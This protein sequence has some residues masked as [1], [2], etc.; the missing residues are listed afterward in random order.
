MYREYLWYVLKHKWYVFLACCKEGMPVRGLLH[1]MSKLRPSEFLPYAKFHANKRRDA[2]GHYRST[3]TGDEKFDYAWFL[4]QKR[5]PH[6]WQHW[7]QVSEE[8]SI[9]CMPIPEVYL[10]EMLCDWDGA[11]K[12]QGFFNEDNVRNHYL[13]NRTKRFMH[14]DATAYIEKRLEV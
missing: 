10:R 14:P 12:A 13:N 8:G 7:C 2:T 1:D 6:H 9:I 11:G 4:H 5:Q 3:E